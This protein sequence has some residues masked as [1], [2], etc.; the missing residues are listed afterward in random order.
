[1]RAFCKIF[2]LLRDDSRLI[3]SRSL[4]SSKLL[5]GLVIDD[6]FAASVEEVGSDNKASAA[7]ECYE[8]SQQAYDFASLLGSPQKD[9][10]AE[11]EG[12]LVGTYVNL[13]QRALSRG[14]CTVGAPAMKRVALSHIT[15]ALC[16]LA[17]TTDS[18]HV[19]LL[20]GW[21]AV[22]AYRR[23]LMSLL[24]KSFSLVD[25]NLVGDTE[26]NIVGLTRSVANELVMLA[27]LM[28]L[29]I[30]DLGA[31]YYPLLFA[32]DASIEKGGI[33]STSVPQAVLRALWKSCRS[34]GSYT[35]ILS[36]AERI[37]K[38]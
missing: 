23:P 27:V 38:K 1:M 4:R 31:E 17:H 32:T 19:C 18:L 34:K 12:K 35:R 11:N 36:P 10:V 24:A 8:R 37:L 20:G 16:Q 25:Q 33:C 7:A 3:A 9:V 30:S 15:L 14:L 6:Y 22:L 28:P 13:S 5:Q 21:V 26:A 29:A 2:G